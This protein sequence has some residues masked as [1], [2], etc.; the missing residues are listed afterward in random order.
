M[1]ANIFNIQKFSIHDGPGIRTVVF[2]KGCPLRCLWCSNPESQVAHTQILWDA[3]KCTHCGL[4][5]QSCP[6]RSIT[7]SNE[8][9]EFHHKTCNASECGNL[10]TNRCPGNA[11]EYTG[12]KMSIE[13]VMTA[14]RKDRDFYEESSGGV[15]LSGGEVLVWHEFVRE[16]LLTLQDE[17]IHTA[18][19]TTGYALEPIFQDV[20][21]HANL[22]LF[23]MKHHNTDKH[24]QYTGVSNELILKNMDWAVN[25]GIPVIARIPVIPD[26]NNSPEDAKAFCTLLK[27][28][29]ITKVNLL[30]FHQFG[31]RKYEML[32]LEYTLKDTKALHPEDLID[33]QKIFVSNGFDVTI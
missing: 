25:E 12:N 33:Y 13:E 32:Q 16:L 18:L 9:F 3:G 21:R 6:S 29:G 14:V 17:Q 23:D 19:E 15:T 28:I 7:F 10:C 5:E 1:T 30:P 27:D 26:V 8:H 31:Q 22:L 24:R 4:C 2:F 11:L 20:V